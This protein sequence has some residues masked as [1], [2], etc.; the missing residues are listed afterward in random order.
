MPNLRCPLPSRRAARTDPATTLFVVTSKTFTTLETLRN[1]QSA[2]EWLAANLG[3]GPGGGA[4]F[5]R[6]HRQHR[7]SARVWHRARRRAADVGVGGWPVFALVSG[8]CVDRDPL[9]LG[10]WFDS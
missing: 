6:G 3:G 8:G 4:A 1:A 7:R 2:R 9:R 10:R 5:R